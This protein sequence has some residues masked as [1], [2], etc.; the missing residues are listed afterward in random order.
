[1]NKGFTLA[2]LLGVIVILGVLTV[3]AVSTIDKNIKDGNYK[4]CLAQEKNIIEAAKMYSMDNPTFSGNVTMGTLMTE[5]YLEEDFKN[6]VTNSN[7][8]EDTSVKIEINGSKYSFDVNYKG[9]DVECD[10]LKN[11]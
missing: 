6:P 11:E 7:Y 4:S 10:D 5:G 2:E 3:I 8:N 1:M 9:S